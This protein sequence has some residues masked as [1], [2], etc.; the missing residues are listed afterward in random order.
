MAL[1]VMRK[2]RDKLSDLGLRPQVGHDLPSL[3]DWLCRQGLTSTGNILDFPAQTDLA[4]VEILDDHAK[5]A[6]RS[7]RRKLLIL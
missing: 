1:F 7:D 3:F 2:E 5:Q 6:P 4:G